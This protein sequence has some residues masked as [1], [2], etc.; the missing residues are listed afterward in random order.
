MQCD[1]DVFNKQP[2]VGHTDM[3]IKVIV[4]DKHKISINPMIQNS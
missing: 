1:G 4:R 3:H 2:R